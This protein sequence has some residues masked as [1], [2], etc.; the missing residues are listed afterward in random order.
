[1]G[2][3][4]VTASIAVDVQPASQTGLDINSGTTPIN[5]SL[6]IDERHGDSLTIDSAY[7]V[8][9]G[10]LTSAQLLVISANMPVEVTLA[11]DGTPI[12][13]FSTSRFYLDTPGAAPLNIT[14]CTITP[15]G[16]TT[17]I[18]DVI[19]CG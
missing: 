8:E 18:I 12:A 1:M 11:V 9:F 4:V 2:A 5:A 3:A 13:P 16:A 14:G 19:V 17:P 15:I 10:D 6:N 7:T